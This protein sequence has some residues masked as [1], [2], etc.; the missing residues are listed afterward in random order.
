MQSHAYPSYSSF[1]MYVSNKKKGSILE[2]F[3]G[4]SNILQS[5]SQGKEDL[6][7]PTSTQRKNDYT[8]KHLEVSTSK[9]KHCHHHQK[10]QGDLPLSEERITSQ[11]YLKKDISRRS[12]VI[13]KEANIIIE[14]KKASS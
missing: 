13:F 4:S 8:L 2:A 1:A 14:I 6:K 11:T 3:L 12:I 9:K 10:N 5:S 7:D